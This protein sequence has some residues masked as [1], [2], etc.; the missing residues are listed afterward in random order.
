MALAQRLHRRRREPPGHPHLLDDVP[1]VHPPG[2]HDARGHGDDDALRPGDDPR[3]LLYLYPPLR[4]RDA[5]CGLRRR[6]GP[7]P[8]LGP[9]QPAARGRAHDPGPREDCPAGD[10][11]RRDLLVLAVLHPSGGA[12]D[13]IGEVRGA[14]RRLEDDDDHRPLRPHDPGRG[15]GGHRIGTYPRV[16]DHVLRQRG[17]LRPLPHRQLPDHLVLLPRAPRGLERGAREC[18]VESGVRP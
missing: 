4:R 14:Q 7:L 2:R 5:L 8:G 10:A 11:Q 15:A 3:L 9:L 16:E 13:A 6:G 18:R 1:A 12:P 17:L